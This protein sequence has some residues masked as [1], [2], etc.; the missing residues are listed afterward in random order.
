MRLLLSLF[1]LTRLSRSS[2]TFYSPAQD[3]TPDSA[4]AA[5]FVAI[6]AIHRPRHVWL[7]Q[8]P[9]ARPAGVCLGVSFFLQST[10]L[11]SGN[12]GT[13]ARFP[14]RVRQNVVVG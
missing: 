3:T 11:M 7:L 9:V 10:A 2:P 4:N 1:T 8:K 12:V 14:S 13:D 6:S 5:R